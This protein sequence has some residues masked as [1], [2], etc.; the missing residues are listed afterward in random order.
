MKLNI[1]F[2]IYLFLIEFFGIHSSVCV[3]V[4]SLPFKMHTIKSDTWRSWLERQSSKRE[5]V[6]SS[7]TVGKNFIL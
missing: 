2:T 6:I 7:S 3:H 4:Y 1:K 5:V